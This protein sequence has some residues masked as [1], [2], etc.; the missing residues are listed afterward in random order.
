MHARSGVCL[1]ECVYET[2]VG[3]KTFP[4]WVMFVNVCVTEKKKNRVFVCTLK[5]GRNKNRWGKKKK[6]VFV[7]SNTLLTIC[8]LF[9]ILFP[10]ARQYFWY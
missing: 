8:L 10:K 5:A 9:S 2:P 1:C 3:I 4:N 7:K 6:S